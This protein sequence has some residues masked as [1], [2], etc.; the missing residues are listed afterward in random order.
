MA[1]IVFR[2][3]CRLLPNARNVVWPCLPLLLHL[4]PS[5]A[6]FLSSFPPQ[7][8]CTYY[9]HRLECSSLSSSNVW[10]LPSV[11]FLLKCHPTHPPQGDLLNQLWTQQASIG[12]F[13]L[14]H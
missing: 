3:K 10:L 12:T 8:L 6:F 2:I 9:S 11:K 4:L 1:S 5:L 13:I 14:E 7:S